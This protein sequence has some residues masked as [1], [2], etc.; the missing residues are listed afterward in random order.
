MAETARISELRKR[1]EREPDSRLFAQLAEELRKEGDVAEA[2]QVCR[3][4]LAKHPNYPSARMTLGRALFDTGDLA[5]ARS[6]FEAVVKAAPDNILASRLLAESLEGLGL[7]D[8]AKARY[9]TT[10]AIAPGDKHVQAKLEQ[11]EARPAAKPSR[12]PVD[13]AAPIPLV[14][15]DESFELEPSG[16]AAA[17]APPPV[18]VAARVAAPAVP[19][20]SPAMPE[21]EPVLDDSV[22]WSGT[23]L[24]PGRP[25][26]GGEM[27]ALEPE[28]GEVLA[29][30]PEPMTLPSVAHVEPAPATPILS[31]TM[32]E[33][34]FNQGFTDKAIEVYRGL[35]EQEPGNER[36]RARLT[37]LVGIERHLGRD[38]G[39]EADPRARKRRA[40]ERTIERLEGLMATLARRPQ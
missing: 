38:V 17:Y 37:E 40:I 29:D 30:D 26:F 22:D 21:A 3:N 36:V 14:D 10:L 31:P 34:Y 8:E 7:L 19:A 20:S 18:A 11:L 12:A 16:G 35:L 4:G 32:A 15:A 5:A 39:V 24:P 2:I 6:E 27:P 13:V 25:A 33:L 9:R 28:A 1:L 23:T